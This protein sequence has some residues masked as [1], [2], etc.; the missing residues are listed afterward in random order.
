MQP[1]FISTF[2]LCG[3][4]L[5]LRLEPLWLWCLPQHMHMDLSKQ[6]GWESSKIRHSN[7]NCTLFPQK[8]LMWP[9]TLSEGQSLLITPTAPAS[10]HPCGLLWPHS[11]TSCWCWGPQSRPVLCTNPGR[12]H[13][14]LFPHPPTLCPR[15]GLVW[16]AA[17]LSPHPRGSLGAPCL[18][19]GPSHLWKRATRASPVRKRY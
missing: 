9:G 12:C 13:Q 8:E 10:A 1:D 3:K 5:S 14:L 15:A 2:P 18:A 19:A 6:I 4:K 7:R 17:R 16:G 11:P